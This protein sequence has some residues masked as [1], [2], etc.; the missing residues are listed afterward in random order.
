LTQ[1]RDFSIIVPKK[2]PFGKV[3]AEGPT[4]EM[5]A[6]QA[7]IPKEHDPPTSMGTENPPKE[8]PFPTQG[9]PKKGSAGPY[10]IFQKWDFGEK[11]YVA[12]RDS[13]RRCR[14]LGVVEHRREQLLSPKT[15][16]WSSPFR[17]KNFQSRKMAFLGQKFSKKVPPRDPYGTWSAGKK[18]RGRRPPR[19]THLRRNE[20]AASL[21]NLAEKS[22]MVSWAADSHAQPVCPGKTQKRPKRCSKMGP[23]GAAVSRPRRPPPAVRH[24]GKVVEKEGF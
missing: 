5:E 1:N 23:L 19:S 13:S 2:V 22:R 10:A 17:E 11:I 4:F 20:N 9:P 12:K 16:N 15:G 7:R 8:G 6:R 3:L 14:H 18:L 21:N 24:L